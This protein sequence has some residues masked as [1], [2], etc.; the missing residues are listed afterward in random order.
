MVT[1]KDKKILNLFKILLIST[2]NSVLKFLQ[3]SLNVAF[4]LE[5]KIVYYCFCALCHKGNLTSIRVTQNNHK[6]IL[7]LTRYFVLFT[8][9]IF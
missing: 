3:H 1:E 6:T 2:E 9:K 8:M 5:S 7:M 4:Y